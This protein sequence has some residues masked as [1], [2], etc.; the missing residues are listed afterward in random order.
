MNE[1]EHQWTPTNN[2]GL[3]C[4]CGKSKRPIDLQGQETPVAEDKKEK[5]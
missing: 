2:T 1:H 4:A 5:T 3:T